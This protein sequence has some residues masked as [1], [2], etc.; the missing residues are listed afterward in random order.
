MVAL[1]ALIL[2]IAIIVIF[3]TDDNDFEESEEA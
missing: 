1:G 3:L 2:F